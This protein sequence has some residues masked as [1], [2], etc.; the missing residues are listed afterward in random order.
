MRLNL[1]MQ[2][3]RFFNKIYL[4][5]FLLSHRA[6]RSYGHII[7]MKIYCRF[8][9]FGPGKW[10][11]SPWKVLEKSWNFFGVW[12]ITKKKRANNIMFPIM[13]TRLEK[14]PENDLNINSKLQS[15][16][17]CFFFFARII[18]FSRDCLLLQFY[19]G[20]GKF[21]RFVLWYI[22]SLI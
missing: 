11:K 15:I 3:P 1:S 19:A 2:T 4:V 9:I 18:S 21:W 13:Y 20:P 10:R 8:P 5:Y 22:F 17:L 12:E 14:S 7:S 16:G 6:K